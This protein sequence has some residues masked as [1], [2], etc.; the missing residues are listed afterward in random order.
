MTIRELVLDQATMGINDWIKLGHTNKLTP[1]E[2][3]LLVKCA[4]YYNKIEI[5]QSA[6]FIKAINA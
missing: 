2:M 5:N 6:S 1:M 4:D 3:E